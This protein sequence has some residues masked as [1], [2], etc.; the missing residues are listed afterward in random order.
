MAA[1]IGE[2]A[3]RLA[4]P[5]GIPRRSWSDLRTVLA[6]AVESLANGSSFRSRREIRSIEA[7]APTS[8]A[9]CQ[10]PTA[11]VRRC[12]SGP[13]RSSPPPDVVHARSIRSPS[14]G[15]WPASPASG[16]IL[17]PWR[18]RSRPDGGLGPKTS[19]VGEASPWRHGHV[20][21]CMASRASRCRTARCLAR[22][23]DT[24]RAQSPAANHGHRVARSSRGE[25]GLGGRRPGDA[26][27][28]RPCGG[29]GRDR[30]PGRL[31]PSRDPGQHH[32]IR[33]YEW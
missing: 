6:T 33:I 7:R 19:H 5:P 12:R 31:I 15:P 10:R 16:L 17:P 1:G 8:R 21:P 14:P 25:A 20:A 32:P 4:R 28:R 2:P 27:A 26:R 24:E 18:R 23:A 22:G 30:Y 9:P 29:G 11:R 3:C 13:L